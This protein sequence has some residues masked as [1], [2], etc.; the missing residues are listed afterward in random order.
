M[1]LASVSPR[2]MSSALITD[3]YLVPTYLYN[4]VGQPT[5]TVDRVD[6]VLTQYYN[7]S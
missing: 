3:T 4:Y 1:N 7:T 5:K 6:A 2:P